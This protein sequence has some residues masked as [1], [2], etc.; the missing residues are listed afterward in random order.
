MEQ[1]SKKCHFSGDV[2][3]TR[4]FCCLE[5][6]SFSKPKPGPHIYFY[7]FF[8]FL[9]KIQDSSKIQKNSYGML[10]INGKLN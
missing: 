10:E 9:N 7:L 4:P 5:M 3:F 6:C 8:F 2:F 1:K